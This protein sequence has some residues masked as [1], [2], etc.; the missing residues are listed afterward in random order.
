MRTM[1]L[2]VLAFCV[3]NCTAAERETVADGGAQPS[4]AAGV[5]PP[6]VPAA[7]PSISIPYAMRGGA[8]AGGSDGWH[9]VIDEERMLIASP[10]SAGWYVVS[11]PQHERID[12]RLI[13][14]TDRLTIAIEPGGCTVAQ[15]RTVRP[16]RATLEWDGGTFEGCGGPR[17]PPADIT[18]SVWE[19]V[20]LGDAIAPRDRSPA[21]TLSFSADG[22]V[23][24]T[25]VCNNIGTA[26]RWRPGGSFERGPERYAFVG[27]QIGCFGP[28]HAIG[29]SFWNMVGSAT[30]WRR[31]GE[32][33][34][35]TGTHGEMAELRFLVGR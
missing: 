11:R 15:Q 30:R 7:P 22:R 24:G 27:T 14:R 8:S 32:A 34:V 4:T 20:R 25:H 21:A 28:G 1:P 17:V 6:L 19:L 3:S 23:G 2:L 18:N 5:L 10:T 29:Q 26:M 9:A 31:D 33:L 13:F 35:I 16:D 12:G